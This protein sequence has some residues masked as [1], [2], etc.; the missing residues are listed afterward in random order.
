MKS[1]PDLEWMLERKQR[2]IRIP[3]RLCQLALSRMC[4]RQMSPPTC[5]SIMSYKLI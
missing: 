1:P 5:C 2:Q 4:R 3:S